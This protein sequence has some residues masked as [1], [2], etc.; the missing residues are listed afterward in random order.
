MDAIAKRV[1]VYRFVKRFTSGDIVREFGDGS[2]KV[3]EDDLERWKERLEALKKK[4]KEKKKKKRDSSSTEHDL[5]VIVADIADAKREIKKAEYDLKCYESW[6]MH[7]TKNLPGSKEPK[8]WL[9][10][11]GTKKG[12]RTL[13][14]LDETQFIDFAEL[15]FGLGDVYIFYK[16]L[17]KMKQ[18]SKK[19]MY[20]AVFQEFDK[21]F[22]KTLKKRGPKVE[23]RDL[24]LAVNE[25]KFTEEQREKL[26]KEI[27][28]VHD[29]AFANMY[30]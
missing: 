15:Q 7:Y 19:K 21:V 18:L 5:M 22:Q 4:H 17:N 3:W 14:D 20:T 28:K 10:N 26:L 2:R 16:A 24:V 11:A 9:E 8:F 12:V 6:A 25:T 1:K 29:L 23:I 13:G 30:E 27:D